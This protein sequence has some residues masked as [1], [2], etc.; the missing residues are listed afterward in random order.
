MYSARVSTFAATSDSAP[1]SSTAFA[2]A[3]SSV[4][5]AGAHGSDEPAVKVTMPPDSDSVTS[6]PVAVIANAV[7]WKRL[8]L[9]EIVPAASNAKV[10]VRLDHI[11]E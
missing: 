6:I 3:A 11:V 2:A 5:A 1:K 8:V 10:G 4:S 7:A 9:N